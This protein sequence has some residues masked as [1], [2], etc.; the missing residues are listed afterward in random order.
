M[1]AMFGWTGVSAGPFDNGFC[2]ISVWADGLSLFV[3]GGI[4]NDGSV[5]IATSPDGTTWTTR[6]NPWGAGGTC[7]GMAWSEPLGLLVAA[8]VG[9]S[10]SSAALF[11]SPDGITWTSRGNPA[12]TTSGTDPF[13]ANTVALAWSDDFSLF[14]GVGNTPGP[15]DTGGVGVAIVSSSDGISWTQVPS[16]IDASGYNGNSLTAVAYSTELGVWSAVGQFT[17]TLGGLQ[18]YLYSYDAATW[19]IGATPWDGSSGVVTVAAV[20]ESGGLILISGPVEG[21][22]APIQ[23]SIDGTTWADSASTLP[24]KLAVGFADVG[25]GIVAVGDTQ[26][27]SSPAAVSDTWVLET[28]FFS[29][30]IAIGVVWSYPLRTVLAYG[31]TSGETMAL[32]TPL[33]PAGAA[34]FFHAHYAS[35]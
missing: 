7:I 3:A 35:V 28:S 13:A 34:A 6:G 33:I 14:V 19:T 12:N 29:P 18:G 11:T 25:D 23:Q 2:N 8:G 24:V 16:P 15:D 1:S 31:E 26:I 30:G 4:S 17:T 32:G 21:G 5:A 20:S 9:D 27:S 22:F 10:Y